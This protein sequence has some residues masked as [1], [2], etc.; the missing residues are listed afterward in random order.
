MLDDDIG[1]TGTASPQ[2]AAQAAHLLLQGGYLGRQGVGPGGSGGRGG[3]GGGGSQCGRCPGV[4]VG[5]QGVETGRNG[6]K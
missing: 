3:R 2:P 1:R 5:L 6:L 4:G